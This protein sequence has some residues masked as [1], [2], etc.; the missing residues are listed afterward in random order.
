MNNKAR[1][2]SQLTHQEMVR[3]AP[4]KP[5][6]TYTPPVADPPFEGR[7]VR[8]IFSRSLCNAHRLASAAERDKCDDGIPCTKLAACLKLADTTLAYL[9]Y[10]NRK[11]D[12][13]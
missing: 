12:D 7:T 6:T 4:N 9:D 3:G 8:G 13:V 5:E 2:A 1:K 11:P 10:R